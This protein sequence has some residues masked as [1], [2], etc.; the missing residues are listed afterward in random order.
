MELAN[1]DIWDKIEKLKLSWRICRTRRHRMMLSPSGK[2]LRANGA[3]NWLRLTLRR[4]IITM[5]LNRGTLRSCYGLAQADAEEM[6]DEKA[7]NDAQSS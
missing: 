4:N 6:W 3:K 5:T 1:D 7:W 2:P